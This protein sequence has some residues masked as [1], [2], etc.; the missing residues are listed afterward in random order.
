VDSYH[1]EKV[2]F[3]GDLSRMVNRNDKAIVATGVNG[4]VVFREGEFCDGYGETVKS[5]RFLK[6]GQPARASV[7]A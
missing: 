7:S 4:V 3:Y 5:G 6:A 1:E 2:P